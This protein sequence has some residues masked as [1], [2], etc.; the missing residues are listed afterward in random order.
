MCT[1]LLFFC[2]LLLIHF[3]GYRGFISIASISCAQFN[4]AY[5]F[6]TLLYHICNF[7]ARS[8]LSSVLLLCLLLIF[9]KQI[10]HMESQEP[11][12]ICAS[13]NFFNGIFATHSL[14]YSNRMVK[15]IS[16][17]RIFKNIMR[18]HVYSLQGLL[19]GGFPK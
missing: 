3:I 2:F 11:L 1:Y 4:V 14:I 8:K 7:L 19:L 6:Q 18:I 5:D 10:L 15:K 17:T 9:M 13:E 16:Q 12:A